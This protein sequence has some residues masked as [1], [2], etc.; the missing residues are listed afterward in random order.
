MIGAACLAGQVV[1]ELGHLVGADEPR[2]LALRVA[3]QQAFEVALGVAAAVRVGLV[4]QHGGHD[5]GRTDRVDA[6]QVGGELE[7]ERL[8][9]QAHAALGGRVDRRLGRAHHAGVRGDVDDAALR[10]A[11][12]GDGV[13]AAEERALEVDRHDAL[14]VGFGHGLAGTLDPE[15]G[16]VDEHVEAAG[17]GDRHGDHALAVAHDRDVG[18]DRVD[19][20]AGSRASSPTAAASRSAR[21]S[22]AKTCAPA[23]RKRR[24]TALPMPPAAPVIRT[25]LFS[26][27][28]AMAPPSATARHAALGAPAGRPVQRRRR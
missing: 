11:Q 14:P 3:A 1:D 13:A 19:G 9:E 25:T 6:H 5:V 4:A 20:G 24:A 28:A 16:A 23:S 18:L 22:A 27:S 2:P 8:G 7:G 21:R 17:A 15:A 12:L 10:L 26:C